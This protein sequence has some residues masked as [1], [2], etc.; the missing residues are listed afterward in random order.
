MSC[1]SVGLAIATTELIE[2]FDDVDTETFKQGLIRCFG[3]QNEKEFF[4]KILL[5]SGSQS[6]LSLNTLNNIHTLAINISNKSQYPITKSSNICL[7]S[8]SSN[9]IHCIGKYLTITESKNVGY[10]NRNLYIETQK[11]SFIINRRNKN[12]KIFTIDREF[13]DIIKRL[14]NITGNVFQ[15]PL[16]AD[17]GGTTP[18]AYDWHEIGEKEKMIFTNS[19][20]HHN[21]YFNQLLNN[22]KSIRI[23][24]FWSSILPIDALFCANNSIEKR[25]NQLDIVFPTLGVYYNHLETFLNNL[26]MKNYCNHSST[27]SK[28]NTN[29]DSKPLHM[30]MINNLQLNTRVAIILIHH[31]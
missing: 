6:H 12:D 18:E 3:C 9:I 11:K 25:Q 23:N 21:N 26:N 13:M 4:C 10:C 14:P 1:S 22:V 19:F 20:T 15:Y 7:S 30:R 24:H 8:L 16:S 29:S 27:Q 28:M 17:F 31:Q 2:G 5:Y